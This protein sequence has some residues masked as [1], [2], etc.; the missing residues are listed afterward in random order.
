MNLFKSKPKLA[1]ILSTF[2]KVEDDLLV[3]MDVNAKSIKDKEDALAIQRKEQ[4]KARNVLKRV[5]YITGGHE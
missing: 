5:S 3:F 1:N 2:T 4:E